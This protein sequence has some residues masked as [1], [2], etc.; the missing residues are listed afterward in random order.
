MDQ[1]AHQHLL[2]D[3]VLATQADGHLF[4]E[5]RHRADLL[6]VAARPSARSRAPKDSRAVKPAKS[7][8]RRGRATSPAR[9]A[10]V[11][12]VPP[13][14]QLR[15][16]ARALGDD[17]VFFAYARSLPE[18]RAMVSAHLGTP[19]EALVIELAPLED[20]VVRVTHGARKTG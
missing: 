20:E 11:E 5:L 3:D 9:S 15:Y 7:I 8:K 1:R 13:P 4:A 18:A 19:A 17:R 14:P 12:L 10:V 6:V 16:R 2:H